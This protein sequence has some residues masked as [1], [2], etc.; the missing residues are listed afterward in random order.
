MAGTNTNAKMILIGIL[1]ILVVVIMSSQSYLKASEKT[2]TRG[3]SANTTA[4]TN[5]PA[6]EVKD[7]TG[8]CSKESEAKA[9]PSC[10]PGSAAVPAI[11]AEYQ[12]DK[13]V[14][15]P[16]ELQ[17]DVIQLKNDIINLQPESKQVKSVLQ[18]NTAGLHAQSV[19]EAA[20][21][22]C[23]EQVQQYLA[24]ALQSNPSSLAG[25]IIRESAQKVLHKHT[26]GCKENSATASIQQS[27][28]KLQA[29]Q[30][31]KVQAVQH[32]N[33][34]PTA[35]KEAVA[36]LQSDTA[37]LQSDENKYAT[38]SIPLVSA[39]SSFTGPHICI[40]NCS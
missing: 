30:Q 17:S 19:E 4:G 36:K 33:V 18:S 21:A 3:P 31:N 8:I 11:M 28:A 32:A 16:N 2:F 20:A 14:P 29:Q 24:K 40:S 39:L 27:V 38:R 9:C 10:N 13:I 12:S 34:S 26:E 25:D 6:G 1:A 15:N 37:K 22:A 23:K 7:Y 35:W 5:C